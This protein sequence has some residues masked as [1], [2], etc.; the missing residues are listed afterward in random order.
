[1]TSL[2]LIKELLPTGLA[3]SAVDERTVMTLELTACHE[4]GGL[5]FAESFHGVDSTSFEAV[6]VP[7]LS[8]GAGGVWGLWT[9][10]LP[11]IAYAWP[12]A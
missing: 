4:G 12:S 2:F 9:L 7:A 3:I 10:A 1:M 5:C 6:G 11:G 8:S